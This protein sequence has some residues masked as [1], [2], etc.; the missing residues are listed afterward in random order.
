MKKAMIAIV[1]VIY[2][3]A[4]IIVAFLGV[5]AE[6]IR[7]QER[8]D[9]TGITLVDM[10]ENTPGEVV[11]YYFDGPQNEEQILYTAYSRPEVLDDEG[12]D[13]YGN[14][15]KVPTS[16]ENVYYDFILRI[17]KWKWLYNYEWRD[18][19]TNFKVQGKVVPDNASQQ[20]LVYSTTE[21]NNG[22]IYTLDNDTGL[23]HFEQ[24]LIN[25]RLTIPITVSTTDNSGIRIR[26]KVQIDKAGTN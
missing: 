16:E 4:I 1:S 18:G 23:I 20:D 3:I 12:Y 24:E 7:S 2:L 19:K 11:N 8:V 17:K 21:G 13:E 9:A 10:K 15:W 26:V 25:T 22:T 6:F 5:R 14:L